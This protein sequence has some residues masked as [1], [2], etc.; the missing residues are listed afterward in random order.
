MS[1]IEL[2]GSKQRTAFPRHQDFGE[3]QTHE[4]SYVNSTRS[5]R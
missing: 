4:Y 2:R 1:R 3:A 5:E